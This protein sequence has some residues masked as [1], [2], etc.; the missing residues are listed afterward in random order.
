ME[1]QLKLWL[2]AMLA[3]PHALLTSTPFLFHVILR[4]R[5]VAVGLHHYV[6]KQ[7]L[8]NRNGGQEPQIVINFKIITTANRTTM[9]FRCEHITTNPLVTI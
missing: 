8:T 5:T 4:K 3:S 7:E 9:R 6:S 2:I 1:S